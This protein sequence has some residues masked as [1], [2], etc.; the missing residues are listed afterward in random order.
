[1]GSHEP[2]LLELRTQA[3][4]KCGSLIW[5]LDGIDVLEKAALPKKENLALNY[6]ELGAHFCAAL[7]ELG[8]SHTGSEGKKRE[9]EKMIGNSNFQNQ[10]NLPSYFE[11]QIMSDVFPQVGFTSYRL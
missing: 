9:M 4:F 6:L 7:K 1:M 10:N 11:F 8:Q 3:G 2:T 5:N